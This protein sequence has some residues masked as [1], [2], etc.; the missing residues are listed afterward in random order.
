MNKFRIIVT[1]LIC[2]AVLLAGTPKGIAAE[3]MYDFYEETGQVSGSQY[4][5]Q[6]ELSYLNSDDDLTFEN[7]FGKIDFSTELQDEID[8][9]TSEGFEIDAIGYTKVY[10]KEVDEEMIPMTQLEINNYINNKNQITPFATGP[11]S[12][13]PGGNFTLYTIAS[14]RGPA[15]DRIIQAS[16]VG[17]YKT[18]TFQGASS[19][20]NEGKYNYI[21]LAFP[22]QYTLT[23]ASVSTS[24][25]GSYRADETNNSVAYGVMLAS[26]A[27][28]LKGLYNVTL[29]AQ[30]RE[31]SGISTKKIISGYAH[32]YSSPQLGLSLS[33]SGASFSLSVE[34]NTWKVFSSV[35]MS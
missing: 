28:A 27:P 24:N 25:Y 30:G 16:S 5:S 33:P 10:L 13:G 14:Y 18:Y 11:V 15:S 1:S 31:N 21:S 7:D 23:T 9:L 19:R 6:T 26:T 12:P 35:L 2:F 20:P 34:K 32:N 4:I 22:T 3:E 17:S 8:R 29:N